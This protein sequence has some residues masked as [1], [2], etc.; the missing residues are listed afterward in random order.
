[1]STKALAA[2]NGF[3][4]DVL[5]SDLGMAEQDGYDLIRQVR[6]RGWSGELLPA[7]AV[8]AFARQED[9]LRALGAGYQAHFPKP[10]ELQA[11]LGEIRLLVDS[12]R[13]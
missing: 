5:V 9:R 7:I 2:L 8:T 12:R 4:P 13:R 11:F 1:M 6:E 10:L 3:S